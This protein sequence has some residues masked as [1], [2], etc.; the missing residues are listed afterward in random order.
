MNIS[1]LFIYFVLI[2]P[3]ARKNAKEKICI[4]LYSNV[5][6]ANKKPVGSFCLP[7]GKMCFCL[8]C[9]CFGSVALFQNRP[10][11][12]ICNHSCIAAK[13]SCFN[14]WFRTNKCFSSNFH[15]FFRYCSME[16]GSRD[17]NS[18]LIS[19]F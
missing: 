5:H 8:R 15:L 6:W 3:L 4:L 1:K 7:T 11:G 13:P 17:I 10:I 2:P 18:Y 19:L 12:C 16:F 9:L 14:S